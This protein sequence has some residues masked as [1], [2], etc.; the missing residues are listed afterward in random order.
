MCT[1]IFDNKYGH[2]FGR[3]LDLDFSYGEEVVKT[4]KGS[5]LSFFHEGKITARFDYIGMAHKVRRGEGEEEI[6]LY[7]D[8]M[9]EGGLCIAALNFPGYAVYNEKKD[10]CRNLASFEVIP[11]I[12]A[13]CG[14][15]DCVK[16]L[17]CGANITSGAF[18][19]S[20]PPTPLHWMVADRGS[21]IVIE[22]GERG[23]MIYENTVGVMTNA[24]S[25]DY[26]MTRLSDYMSMS[27][28]PP[29]N[30]LYPDT[31]LRSYSR[32][33]GAVG[34]PGDFSSG[35]RFVR[36]VYVKAHTL[37][38]SKA[39]FDGEQEGASVERFFKIMSSVS[40]PLGCIMTD[41][42]KPVCTVYT[43]VCDMDTLTYRYFTYT[44]RTVK[45]ISLR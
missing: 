36:A 35:S 20:L 25:F 8:G 29:T 31:E 30:T 23:L 40:V 7:Y 24:P 18:S 33:M 3:T 4:H 19:P 39:L 10:K 21:S 2:F 5:E 13:N 12:L 38:P 22:Q 45:A 27:P 32:G 43:S 42:D 6:P 1:S 44:D 41:E 14:N 37:M 17:L 28:A 11:Y 9:N 26:H 16:K 15:I 34:L